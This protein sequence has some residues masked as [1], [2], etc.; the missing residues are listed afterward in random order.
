MKDPDDV[1]AYRKS[2]ERLRVHIFLAGLDDCFKQVRGDI[3]RKDSIPN[4]EECYA[5]IRHEANRQVTCKGESKNSETPAMVARNKLRAGRIDK[6]SYKY[7]HCNETGHTRERCHE[8]I[9]YAEW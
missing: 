8:L 4:L 9:G 7:T 1:E 2:L 5:Q 6:S 3:L